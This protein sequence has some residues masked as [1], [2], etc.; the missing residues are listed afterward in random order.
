MRSTTHGRWLAL[1][2]AFLLQGCPQLL[3]DNFLPAPAPSGSGP[4]PCVGERCDV[5]IPPLPGAR[6]AGG[7]PAPPPRPPPGTRGDDASVPLDAGATAVPSCWT[8]L[9]N[10]STHSAA[11]NCLD[12][13]GWNNAVVDEDTASSVTRTYADGKVCLSGQLDDE[14]WG[15]VYN[16]TFADDAAWNPSARGVSGIELEVSGPNP[17]ASAEVIYTVNGNQDFCRAV[18]PFVT[19]T[20]PFSSTHP[21]CSTNAAAA[22]PNVAALTHLRL[23]LPV[24]TTPRAY[25]FC[26]G[27]R[28][29][30]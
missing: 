23:H 18:E 25:D 7:P 8:V 2:G 21:D 16:F 15:M 13:F 10:D 12:I 19:T 1:T 20:V 24:G 26:L 3:D 22:T 30:R 17:P 5:E 14:G 9:L 27:L 6:D 4:A 11:N 28:G 29:A